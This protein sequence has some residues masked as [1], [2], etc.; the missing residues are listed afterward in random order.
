M[1]VIN[2]LIKLIGYIGIGI[3]A[4]FE[5]YIIS[6]FCV[7]ILASLVCSVWSF[8][9][10]VPVYISQHYGVLILQGAI[11]LSIG[12]FIFILRNVKK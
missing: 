2:K 5:S 7:S 4:L 9:T 8:I 1:K 11:P 10:P 12:F 6:L 3:I